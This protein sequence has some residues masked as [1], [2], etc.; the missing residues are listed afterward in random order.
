MSA[1]RRLRVF[2][3]ASVPLPSRHPRY[4]ETADVL[5]IRDAVR[6]LA[7]A[8]AERD[9][10]LVFGGHPAITPVIRLQMA[11]RDGRVGQRF[12]IYQSR[13][14]RKDFPPDNDAFERVVLTPEVPGSR[15]A[16][17]AA[18][19]EEMFGAPLHAAVLIGGMEGVEEEHELFR[20]RHPRAPTFPIAS[21]G[22]AAAILFQRQAGA[23]GWSTELSSDVSYLG[24]MR[25][26]LDRA[27]ESMANGAG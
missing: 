8:V 2:L 14:F 12:V 13:F 11:T 15:E 23:M 27:S 6:G 5:A 21:T 19:R 25:S 17:L 10:T 26:I 7:M 22:A 1:A 16:S 24:L 20:L 4:F 9:A 18:M 3:S